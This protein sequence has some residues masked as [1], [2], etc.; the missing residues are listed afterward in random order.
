[1]TSIKPYRWHFIA[2][3][4][5]FATVQTMDYNEQVDEEE[6]F[7]DACLCVSDCLQPQEE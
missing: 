3:A 2:L 1:M 5:I 6:C 7:T 4:I